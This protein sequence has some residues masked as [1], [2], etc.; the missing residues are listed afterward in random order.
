LQNV[1]SSFSKEILERWSGTDSLEVLSQRPKLLSKEER[2]TDTCKDE[3]GDKGLRYGN[4]TK[5]C[6]THSLLF[7]VTYI[8]RI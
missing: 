8:I 2:K 7:L 1:D 3:E 6:G 5:E 4:N